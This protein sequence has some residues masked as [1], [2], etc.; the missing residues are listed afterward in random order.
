MQPSYKGWE[1]GPRK[2]EF[3]CKTLSARSLPIS[4][5]TFDRP[6]V[7]N[8]NAS[9]SASAGCWPTAPHHIA[10]SCY[11][12]IKRFP[13]R[14]QALPQ[15]VLRLIRRIL[16]KATVGRWANGK[17]ESPDINPSNDLTMPGY[18][19]EGYQTTYKVMCRSNL[20]PCQP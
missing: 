6:V 19:P 10:T 2:G 7:V 17:G 4:V 12:S 18:M 20:S 9:E 3:T 1:N 11:W 5:S 16:A 15:A 8:R 14:T 13:A